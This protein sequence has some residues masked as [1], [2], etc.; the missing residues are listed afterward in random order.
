MSYCVIPAVIRV[1]VHAWCRNSVSTGKPVYERGLTV[2]ISI[3]IFLTDA[4]RKVMY[5]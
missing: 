1:Q 3:V 5:A 4:L 2:A